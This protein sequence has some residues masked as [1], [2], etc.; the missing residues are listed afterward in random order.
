MNVVL[1]GKRI[2][3]DLARLG[4]KLKV[5]ADQVYVPKPEDVLYTIGGQWKQRY[6]VRKDDELYISP[7]HYNADSDRFENYHEADWDKRPWLKNCGGCHAPGLDLEAK[8]FTE[9]GVGC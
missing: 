4:D 9:P 5:P 3:D 7:V 8:T 2:R 1:D 6:I